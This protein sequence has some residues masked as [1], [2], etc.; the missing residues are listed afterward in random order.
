[1]TSDRVDPA[2]DRRGEGD[3]R[4]EVPPAHRPEDNDQPEEDEG[5][6]Q[7][8]YSEVGSGLRRGVGLH[9]ERDHHPDHED[10]E[11]RSDQFR[12]IGGEPSILHVYEPPRW[13]A[14]GSVYTS[15]AAQAAVGRWF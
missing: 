9:V 1:L 3:H 14:G 12:D 15:A 11:K 5:L 10:Q 13:D 2:Q 4:V 6:R 7:S 8:D